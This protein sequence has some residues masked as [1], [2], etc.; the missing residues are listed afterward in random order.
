MTLRIISAQRQEEIT[1]DRDIVT[2]DAF[3]DSID[4]GS[5]GETFKS[6]HGES[7]FAC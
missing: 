6:A 4:G 5:L 1:L 2:G 3:M 7:S